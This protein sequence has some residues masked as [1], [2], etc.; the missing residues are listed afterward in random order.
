MRN[1]LKNI[2]L[3]VLGLLVLGLFGAFVN[4]STESSQV[5]RYVPVDDDNPDGWRLRILDTKTG[6]LYFVRG[7]Q[8]YYSEGVKGAEPA[9]SITLSE[10]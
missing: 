4:V 6:R 2:A 7:G 10:D 1:N 9:R 5:G 8:M 3:G